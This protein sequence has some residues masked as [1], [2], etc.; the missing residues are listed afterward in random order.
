MSQQL[1]AIA[2]VLALLSELGAIPAQ[3][4]DYDLVILNGRV[5]DPES[6]LDEVRNVG[7]KDG[8][9]S[10]SPRRQSRARRPSMPRATSSRRV[11]S[12][13]ITTMWYRH[14]GRKLALRDG[15]TTPMECEFGVLPVD[16]WYASWEGKA[17]TNY[18]A[19]ASLQGAREMVLNPKYKTIAGATISD[20]ELGSLT[21]FDM[22]WSTKIATEDQVEKILEL[23]EEG[24]K[25]GSL[26]VGYTPGYMVSGVRTEEGIGAQRLAGK[27]GRL[28]A[29]HG[30]FSSQM[31]PTDG[32]TG[33]Q[34]T[35]GVG[36]LRMAAD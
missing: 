9:S 2:I 8:K 28:V 30:R 6:G 31:P 21:S 25:Q 29:M 1:R 17:Q 36:R 27:Y 7:I 24:L 12:I 19:T 16:M 11:S 14:S 13:A 34:R 18:G 20:V 10:P 3:A 35:A 4:K 32:L 5:M 22:A 15:I 33:N 26:G 23:V